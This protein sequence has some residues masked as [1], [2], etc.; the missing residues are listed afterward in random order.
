MWKNPWLWAFVLGAV[1]L[2]SIRD[3]M[4]HVPDPPKVVGEVPEWSLVGH[5]G[6]PF[7]SAQLSGDVYVVGF[8]FSTCVTICPALQQA[9]KKLQDRF[10]IHELPVRLVSITVDPDNDTPEVLTE[11][12]KTLGADLDRWTF[13]SGE[14]AKVRSVIVDGF[15]TF[16]GEKAPVEERPGVF[17]VGHGGRLILVDGDGNVRG[18]YEVLTRSDDARVWAMDELGVDEVFHRAR[19]TV[20]AARQGSRDTFSCSMGTGLP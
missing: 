1:F 9:M 4:R 8:F 15:A 20:Q 17:D 3:S 6:E 13:V 14:E 2:T 10:E 11:Y 18:H 12:G 16:M 19:R 7:G 5:D